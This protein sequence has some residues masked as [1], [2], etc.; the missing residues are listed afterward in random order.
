[1]PVTTTIPSNL[2][3]PGT[4]Q[5]FDVT[6]AQRGLVPIRWRAV[7][8]GAFTTGAPAVALVPVQIFSIADSDA[9]FG[10][11][12]EIAIM[13]R[14]SFK[15]AALY[16]TSPE[17][18]AIPIADPGG[19]VKATKTF[20]FNG[21]ATASGN[22][23]LL[24][25]GRPVLVGVKVGDVQNTI[26]TNAQKAFAA[27]ANNLPAVFTVATNVATGTAINA[28][29]NGNDMTASVVSSVTGVTVAV[30]SP[31]AGVGAYDITTALDV[32]VDKTYHGKAIA[33][34]TT[35]DITK[36]GTHLD[37]VNAA[38]TKRFSFAYLAETGT[39]S[40]GTT[41]STAANRMDI[42]VVSAESCPGM[43]GE[44]AAQVATTINA[45]DD[46]ALS[47][48]NVLLDLPLPPAAAVPTNAEVETALAAGAFILGVSESSGKM[49]IIRAVTT[50]T[51]LS[52]ATFLATLD[53]CVVR[54]LFWL[55]EQIDNRWKIDFPR[56]KKST[57]TK[58]RVYSSTLDV[59]KQAELIERIQNVD[60]HKGELV[61]DDDPVV[62]PRLN[63][64][65]PASVISPAH[66]LVG[67]HILI[68]E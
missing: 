49:R 25:A 31:V 9:Y 64:S 18:W 39:L 5:E 56:A 38:D 55:A 23:S 43:P 17:I 19:G 26:A 24:F 29:V 34:H 40:A 37:V 2:L 48:N 11:G 47:H 46:T 32:L 20:T 59:L 45:E 51:T 3:R 15:A 7:N 35:T 21:T 58:K 63:V 65:V 36:L 42:V 57:R 6:S 22:I 27:I 1:M 8:I 44:V 12:S 10:A 13:N 52:G 68:L 66:Q 16:K 62:I 53:I 33:N 67:H 4:F 61:V 50:K 54:T 28:G 14:A 30:A 60:A 41:L